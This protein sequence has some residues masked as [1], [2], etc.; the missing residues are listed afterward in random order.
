MKIKHCSHSA[1]NSYN[2][3]VF[4]YYLSR[5]L[6]LETVSGKAALQGTIVHE[7]LE[8]MA[9]IN[10]HDKKPID[11]MIILEKKWEKHVK[12]N[13]HI[14]IRRTT[15]RGEAAD[16]RKCRES[17]EK[18][19]ASSYNPYQINKVIRTEKWFSIEHT[20]PEWQTYD[21]GQFKSRGFIDL[22][23]EI[24][25]NTL[26]IVDY[27]TGKKQ[28]LGNFKDKDFWD[29]IND[30]QPRLYHLA[31]RELYPNYDNIIV[32]FYYINEGGP[33]SFSFN[34]LDELE[35]I[36]RIR[37]FFEEVKKRKLVTRNRCWKCKMCSFNK[38]NFCDIIWSD[39]KM[40]GL[41]YLEKEYKNMSFKQQQ[42]LT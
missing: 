15:T 21:G 32:T 9:K 2:F 35:T 6:G 22:I 12:L 4:Q 1:I 33:I 37:S 27:K 18:V 3:C 7:V 19:L 40:F 31:V 5:I 30:L 34:E 29:L 20:G 16:F 23:L 11:P 24:D 42:D 38:G 28:D 14:E 10:L 39:F 41:D 26:E 17:V 8:T 36:N 13:P 25:D